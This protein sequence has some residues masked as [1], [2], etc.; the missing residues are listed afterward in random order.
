MTAVTVRKFETLPLPE[1]N[2]KTILI[3]ACFIALLTFASGC[4]VA[5]G[6]GGRGQYRGHADVV[7]GPPAIV[8]GPP[9]VIVR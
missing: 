3:V 7:V 6:G 5:E 4:L 9:V 2:M 1:L 8:V